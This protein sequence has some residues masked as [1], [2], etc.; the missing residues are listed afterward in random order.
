MNRIIN[1]CMFI[2]MV[3]LV[4][5]CFIH[6]WC[7]IIILVSTII[8]LFTFSGV[9]VNMYI[10]DYDHFRELFNNAVDKINNN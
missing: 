9:L 5:S 6:I 1:I 2:Y 10:N 7:P 8:S 3:I 4:S